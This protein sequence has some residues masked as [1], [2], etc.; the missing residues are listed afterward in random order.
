MSATHVT[1]RIEF[2]AGHRITRHESRCAHPHG[3]RYVAEVTVAAPE[4]DPAGRV[5]DFG[6]MKQIL[7]AWI[8]EHWDHAC[9]VCEGVSGCG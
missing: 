7:G 6:V 3:H 2:D 9:P 1:R 8:D 4:L 5:V